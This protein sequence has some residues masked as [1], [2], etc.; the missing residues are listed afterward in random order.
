MA[1]PV[2]A[3]VIV[4]SWNTKELTLRCV[5]SVFA[6]NRQARL[7]VIV[8]DNGS[9]DGTTAALRSTY[10]QVRVVANR[11]NLGFARAVNQGLAAA[12]GAM[13]VVMNADAVMLS[14][15]PV[16]RI[17]SFLR[18]QPRVGIVGAT[19]VAPDGKVLARG[20]HFQN[21]ANL[22]KMHLMFASAPVL[23]GRKGMANN[24]PLWVDYVDGA[25]LAVRREVVAEVGP[26]D[27]AYFLYGEDME[28]CLRAR[29][30]GWQV[31]VLPDLVVR[32][33]QGSSATQHLAR[34]LCHNAV[35][36]SH[37]VGQMYGWQ[38]ARVA[39][40]IL[41]L[42]MLLRIP[43]ALVRRSGLAAHYWQALRS[44]LLLSRDLGDLLRDP[45]P[46]ALWTAEKALRPACPGSEQ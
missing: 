37:F 42:G 40:R 14:E 45:W 39:W 28:W 11:E 26:M 31:V 17:Q 25:F 12:K 21:V 16:L 20:R 7:E 41:L 3:S 35:N 27:E 32:H 43:I 29:R 33:H 24:K 19:L 34:A 44:C 38:Q 4:V 23:G 30:A 1:E 8:V 2:A 9:A 22:A 18:A 5:E 10:P 6:K 13:L 36:V 15:E 46:Q